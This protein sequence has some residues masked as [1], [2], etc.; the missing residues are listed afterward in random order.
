MTVG[1]LLLI[2]WAE[3]GPSLL[4]AMQAT[5]S[6]TPRVDAQIGDALAGRAIADRLSVATS[7]DGRTRDQALVAGSAC[8]AD[9]SEARSQ[10]LLHR[11]RAE[12]V[13]HWQHH[14]RPI[15]AETLRKRLHVGSDTARGLVAQLRSNTHV[16]LDGR[17]GTATT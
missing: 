7:E 6:A 4:Y 9:Q 14:R 8:A 5:E 17:S 13:L 10:D 15:S 2:G 12:D 16:A 3:V 1:P 11:A